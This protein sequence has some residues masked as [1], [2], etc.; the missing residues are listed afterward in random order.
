MSNIC[1]TNRVQKGESSKF[2]LQEP[3]EHYLNQVIKM[4]ITYD[5]T[6][7]YHV[8]PGVMS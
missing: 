5:E 1:L 2:T 4:N 7:W 8:S 6:H 3:G